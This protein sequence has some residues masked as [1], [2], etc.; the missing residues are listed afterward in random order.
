M[1]EKTLSLETSG[2]I[3]RLTLRRPDAGNPVDARLVRELIQARETIADDNAVRVLLLSAEGDAFSRGWNWDALLGET[4]DPVAALRSHGIPPDPFGCLS[5]LPQPV[6]CALNGDAIGAGLELALACDVRIAA[7]GARFL[8]PEVSMGLLPLAGG[9]QRLPRLV[10]RGKALEMI[11]T[12]EPVS[13]DEALRI[14]LVSAAV[15]RERLSEEAAAIAQ[16]I[17][18]GGPLAVRY[19]KEAVAH[20][21][22]MPLEQALRFETDLTIILQTTEDRAEGVRAFL[23]KRSPEFKGK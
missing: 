13:A 2:A 5:D 8:V 6:V 7:T 22:E 3:A 4:T 17:A 15:P 18:E 21:I 9:T 11:L 12:G 1:G 14:G 20:G 19:A 23:E 10:G 16:R